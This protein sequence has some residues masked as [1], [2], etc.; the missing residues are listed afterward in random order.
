MIGR[1]KKVPLSEMYGSGGSTGFSAWLQENIDVLNEAVDLSLTRVQS[2]QSSASADVVAQDG[3]GKPVV[4]ENQLDASGDGALG[5]LI[6][7]MASVGSN[8]GIW[9]VGESNDQHVTAVSWLNENA[10]SAAF[11]LLTVEAYRIDNSA[12]APV[13]NL[14]AGPRS[15]GSGGDSGGSQYP[16]GGASSTTAETAGGG[17]EDAGIND[18]SPTDTYVTGDPA[19]GQ[20]PYI[21]GDP[22]AGEEVPPEVVEAEM[23]DSEADAEATPVDASGSSGGS[24]ESESLRRFWNELLDKARERTRIHGETEATGERVV[25]ANAGLAGLDYNYVLRDHD[26]SVELYVDRGEGREGENETI[27]NAL[28]ATQDAIEYNF[29]GDLKWQTSENSS[30]RRIE[31]TVDTGGISDTD[32]WNETQ[33]A[34]VDAM[35]R[36]ERALRSH[37]ARIQI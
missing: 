6:M 25:G 3:S 37:I 11:Y 4:I 9:I 15:G 28:S 21:T 18:V 1:L 19:A 36:L 29:G 17:N 14:V 33:E 7:S 2:E 5:K 24:E 34:M 26:A 30:A 32:R 22:S 27:F 16:L 31:S 20:E 23:S 8:A 13:M 35:I 10:P 12:P